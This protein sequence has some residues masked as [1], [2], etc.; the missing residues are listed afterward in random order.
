[1]FGFFSTRRARVAVVLCAWFGV[2]V[3]AYAQAQTLQFR[4][5]TETQRNGAQ[6]TQIANLA[7]FPT[8]QGAVEEPVN[9]TVPRVPPESMRS[10]RVLMPTGSRN[11]ASFSMSPTPGNDS[12]FGII[13]D[14]TVMLF[15]SKTDPSGNANPFLPQAGIPPAE[16]AGGYGQNWRL[17][18]PLA[19]NISP[20]AR[21]LLVTAYI[22]PKN[23][24]GLV[25]PSLG[26]IALV[27]SEAAVNGMN[28]VVG[29][30]LVPPI[31]LDVGEAS[32]KRW[33]QAP[34]LAGSGRIRHELGGNFNVDP[35]FVEQR[36]APFNTNSVIG[37]RERRCIEDWLE[38]FYSL[39]TWAYERWF[40]APSICT[41]DPRLEVPG[42]M[43]INLT[44]VLELP[45]NVDLTVYEAHEIA[46][47]GVTDFEVAM[48]IA[49]CDDDKDM[50]DASA[51]CTP[52]DREAI[53]AIGELPAPVIRELLREINALGNLAA[54]A[55]DPLHTGNAPLDRWLNENWERAANALN[56]AASIARVSAARVQSETE[57]VNQS[58]RRNNVVKTSCAENRVEPPTDNDQWTCVQSGK[59]QLKVAD[60]RRVALLPNVQAAREIVWNGAAGFNQL[61]RAI[62]NTARQPVGMRD[63]DFARLTPAIAY[64]GAPTGDNLGLVYINDATWPANTTARF[65]FGIE[66]IW[67]PGA[68][69]GDDAGH[70]E[71]WLRLPG[72]AVNR[73]MLAP[74][75]M[76]AL[77]DPAAQYT[78]TRRGNGNVARTY[79]S[80]YF[81]HQ[82]RMYRLTN[83]RIVI[84]HSGM[85]VTAYPVRGARADQV[86]T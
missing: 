32:W 81:R 65:R 60:Q 9:L 70:R 73:Q 67:A 30:L 10:I 50:S 47:G 51:V 72:L 36:T 42:G 7:T 71:D 69:G 61:A 52:N 18:L 33:A 8:F 23:V 5:T 86:N 16:L 59:K 12:I 66:H 1:M 14:N 63:T 64:D 21:H 13:A 80:I 26:N 84:G 41:V 34:M 28:V 27:V 49:F 58:R 19:R 38:S 48:G 35:A 57:P 11:L 45:R 68:G 53:A 40:G 56:A 62:T 74:L 54:A 46:G 24:G 44:P 77:A 15:Y 6:T 22:L 31:S 4:T 78:Q 85:V 82:S 75:I 79:L 3:T 20:S 37:R 2:P 76:Q 29:E 43:Q 25:R 55:P 17:S 83:I 39:G